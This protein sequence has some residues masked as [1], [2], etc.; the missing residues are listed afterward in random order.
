MAL[1]EVKTDLITA[2][3]NQEIA[4]LV[5]LDLSTAFDTV[6]NGI[7]L[8]RLTNL[9]G[10]TATVKTWIASYLTDWTQI[11]KVGSS[12]LSLVTLKVW[13]ATRLCIGTHLV[14]PLHYPTRPNM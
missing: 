2:I 1:L 7:L 5:L 11:V 8:Q 6:D 4:C 12:E 3:E 9:F 14:Y 10:I 13:C